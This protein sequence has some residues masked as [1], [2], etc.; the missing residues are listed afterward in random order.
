MKLNTTRRVI[1][2]G[3]PVQNDLL[4]Y[5]SLVEFCNPGLLGTRSEFRKKYEIPILRGR[6]ADCTDDVGGTSRAVPDA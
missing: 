1:L 4:E 6:D 2:S 5:Y 3:T